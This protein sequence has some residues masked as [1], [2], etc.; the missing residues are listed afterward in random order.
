MDLSGEMA[1][2][3]FAAIMAALGQ[4]WFWKL[5]L[6]EERTIW[7]GCA[8]L[9]AAGTAVAAISILLVALF[10][11]SSLVQTLVILILG[12]FFVLLL[13][14]PVI[15]VVTLIVTGIRLIRREG[16]SLHNMLSLG[17]GCAMVA[18]VVIWPAIR[19]MLGD[20]PV[21]G[22]VFDFL[23]GFIAILLGIFGTA[24]AFYTVA[25][26]VVQWPY[27]HRSYDAVVV[28]GAGLMKDGTVTPLLA[29]RVKR[30]IEAWREHPEAKLIMSGGQG[31]DELQPES[32]AMRAFA[33]SQGV[34]EEAILVEDRSANTRENLTFTEALREKE[35]LTSKGRL[36]VVSDDYHVLRA[37]LIARTLGVAAD[38]A[39]SKVR[40]YF[41]LN[42]LVREWVAY[43]DLRRTFFMKLAGTLLAVY[44]ALYILTSLA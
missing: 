25:G 22:H 33:L 37:L 3:V 13:A 40:L 44:A 43:M 34:P 15:L 2:V 38:G 10:P 8:A 35:D 17:L 6:G 28:L 27:R 7:L 41:A 5:R 31:A 32:H 23:F 24:F 9:V 12:I 42:A 4:L 39:G 19:S 16:R 20:I 21:V 29:N 11:A 14:F 18:Y 26:I 36:L 1:F 30:G